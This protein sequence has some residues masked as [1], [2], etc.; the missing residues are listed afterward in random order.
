MAKQASYPDEADYV[1]VG[2]G[3]AGCAVAGRLA[4]SGASVVLLEA[5]GPDTSIMFRRP[6][7][8]TMIHAEPKLKARF[9]WGFYNAPQ[10]H[11]LGRRIPATR[12][13]LLGGSSSVNGMIFVRG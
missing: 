5:G 9:D 4:E 12:G 11:L 3:S 2:A 1:V 8:I 10:P 6:G 7:M 13:K